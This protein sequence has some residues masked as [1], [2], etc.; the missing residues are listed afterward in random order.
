[1]AEFNCNIQEMFT[2]K[3]NPVCAEHTFDC[4]DFLPVVAITETGYWILYQAILIS[5]TS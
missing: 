2:R 5:F 4:T 3:Y 1:M